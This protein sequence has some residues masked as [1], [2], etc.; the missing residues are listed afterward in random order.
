LKKQFEYEDM[1][2][3]EAPLHDAR[4]EEIESEGKGRRLS[5]AL[6]MEAWL[7]MQPGV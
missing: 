5:E 3:S 2:K 4:N 1:G 7:V 6:G